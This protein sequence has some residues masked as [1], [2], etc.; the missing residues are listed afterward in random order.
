[1][2]AASAIVVDVASVSDDGV[3]CCSLSCGVEQPDH[4]IKNGRV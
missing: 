3:R 2:L 1:M 4:T